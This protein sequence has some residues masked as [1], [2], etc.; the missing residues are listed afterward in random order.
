VIEKIPTRTSWIEPSFTNDA[1]VTTLGNSEGDPNSYSQSLQKSLSPT[2]IQH[3]A[4]AMVDLGLPNGDFTR[5]NS[6]G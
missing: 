2:E 4:L 1:T 6:R 3:P 5:K